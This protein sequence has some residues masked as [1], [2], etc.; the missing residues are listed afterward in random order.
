M[1]EEAHHLRKWWVCEEKRTRTRGQRLRWQREGP[2][3]A[4]AG[5]NE[6]RGGQ[7]ESWGTRRV[8]RAEPAFPQAPRGR[9]ASLQPSTPVTPAT[10]PSHPTGRRPGCRQWHPGPQD[11]GLRKTPLLPVSTQ[12]ATCSQHSGLPC[13]TCLNS[14][15]GHFSFPRCRV[16]TQGLPR[17]LLL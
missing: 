17:N 7:A 4:P 8:R 12:T 15:E 11:A 13:R 9:G 2:R 1:S 5:R 14:P 6:A 3:L 16:W 10:V